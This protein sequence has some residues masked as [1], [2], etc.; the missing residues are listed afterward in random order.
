MKNLVYICIMELK[1]LNL[2][3][4]PLDSSQYINETTDKNQIVLHHTVSGPDG[5]QVVRWWN[6]NEERVATCVVISRNGEIHQAFSSKKW[7]YH[8]GL[9]AKQF[10]KVG[11]PYRNLNK[12]S[13]GIEICAWGPLKYEGGKFYTVYGKEVPAD[14]VEELE[15]PFKNHKFWNSYSPE[16]IDSTVKLIKYWSERYGIPTDYKEDMW[17]VSK[18]AMSGAPGVWTHNSFRKD[19]SDIYPSADLIEALKAI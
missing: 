13:I 5:A 4:T 17:D 1:D 10:A 11:L 19:K 15:T 16:Q 12:S 6:S 3:Q 8:L 7:G 9:G 2:V 18:D 14:Q